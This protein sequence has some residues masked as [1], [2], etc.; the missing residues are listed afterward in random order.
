MKQYI[1]EILTELIDK[2]ERSKVSDGKNQIHVSV[3]IATQKIFSKYLDNEAFELRE[4]V[5]DAIEELLSKGRIEA[6]CSSNHTYPKITLVQDEKVL[7]EVYALLGREKKSDR[8]QKLTQILTTYV[9]KG[10][11]TVAKYCQKQLENLEQ[12]KTVEYFDGDYDELKAILECCI[13]LKNL[14]QEMYYR[15]FSVKQFGDSK[16]FEQLQGKTSS[17]LF[18]YGEFSEKESVFDELG[19]V[20]TPSYIHIKGKRNNLLARRKVAGRR[21]IG[22]RHRHIDRRC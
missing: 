22:R 21:W 19:L 13:A 6:K 18:K 15:N 12:S 9:G 2:Y 7:S 10:N 8:R 5:N 14:S 11:K 17:L 20:K 4:K 3:S 1:K 16:R